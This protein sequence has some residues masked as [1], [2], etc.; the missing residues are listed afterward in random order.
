MITETLVWPFMQ[1]V[2]HLS[3]QNCW[4]LN[5]FLMRRFGSVHYT[6]TQ[7]T[8]TFH[9]SLSIYSDQRRRPGNIHALRANKLL[10]RQNERLAR[11]D[12]LI[13]SSVTFFFFYYFQHPTQSKADMSHCA[14]ALWLIKDLLSSR[15]L[16]LLSFWKF[17]L[18]C[19]TIK[20]F[21]LFPLCFFSK[22]WP[23]SGPIKV[24]P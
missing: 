24:G 23:V 18:R 8:H 3:L 1:R 16:K 11:L 22:W 17:Q 6:Q 7:S 19:Y 12:I 15:T 9:W 14:A 21:S 10:R 4:V 2:A 13:N 5:Y 20:C